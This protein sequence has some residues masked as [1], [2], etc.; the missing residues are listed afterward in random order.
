MIFA[1][2]VRRD[3]ASIFFNYKECG[4][5]IK[6]KYA[7]KSNDSAFKNNLNQEI[8]VLFTHTQEEQTVFVNCSIDF[9]QLLFPD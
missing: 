7:K 3:S 2:D 8:H 9:K 1:E 6:R 5:L 4:I